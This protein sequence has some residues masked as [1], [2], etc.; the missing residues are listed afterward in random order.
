MRIILLLGARIR[1]QALAPP[2]GGAT[3]TGVGALTAQRGRSTGA[4]VP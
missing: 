3:L 2:N 1:R 4:Y